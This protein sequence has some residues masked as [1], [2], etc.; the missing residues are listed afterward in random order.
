MSGRR[1]EGTEVELKADCY[2]SQ[3]HI[4]VIDANMTFD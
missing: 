1:G 3:E 4:N 2:M